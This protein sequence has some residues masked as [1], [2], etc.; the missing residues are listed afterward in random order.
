[1]GGDAAGVFRQAVRSERIN[2]AAEG[3]QVV[4]LADVCHIID[5]VR[6][7]ELGGVLVVAERD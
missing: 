6:Q 1:V 5:G 2:A 4:R 7:R 3:I